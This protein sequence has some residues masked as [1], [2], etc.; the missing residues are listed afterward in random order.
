MGIEISRLLFW[1]RP[2]DE[3]TMIS[4][5]QTRIA[6]LSLRLKNGNEIFPNQEASQEIAKE[7][8][9]EIINGKGKYLKANGNSLP[10]IY[11]WVFGDKHWISV[12][13]DDRRVTYL[14][15]TGEKPACLVEKR[16]PSGKWGRPKKI[17]D[18][19]LVEVGF[20]ISFAEAVAAR[21]LLSGAGTSQENRLPRSVV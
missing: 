12:G 11:A 20:L 8:L 21:T 19:D 2:P 4:D 1:K 14:L 13:E 9:P 3:L 6:V 10:V 16:F 17:E 18:A 5:Y 7:Q 15:K